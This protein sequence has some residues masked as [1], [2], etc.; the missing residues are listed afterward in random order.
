LLSSVDSINEER[1]SSSMLNAP[2]FPGSDLPN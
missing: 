2:S 1:F